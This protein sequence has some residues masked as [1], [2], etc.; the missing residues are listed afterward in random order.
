LSIINTLYNLTPFDNN[1]Q[2]L[3]VFDSSAKAY[4]TAKAEGKA[5]EQYGLMQKQRES[6]ELKGCKF[7]VTS[8]L[9]QL[10][11]VK[12]YYP[13]ASY[14]APHDLSF[15]TMSCPLGTMS[16]RFPP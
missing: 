4:T 13:D 10:Q 9:S 5:L 3:T 2:P 6:G 12:N 11:W 16:R 8:W 15:S 14:Q 7:T 1:L